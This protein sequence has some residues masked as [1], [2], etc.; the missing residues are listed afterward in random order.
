MIHL[1]AGQNYIVERKKMQATAGITVG[2]M[3]LSGTL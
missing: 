1:Y 2:V 3:S